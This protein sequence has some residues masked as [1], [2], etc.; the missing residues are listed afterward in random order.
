MAGA[1]IVTVPVLTG[2]GVGLEPLEQPIRA[3]LENVAMDATILKGIQ[4]CCEHNRVM[5]CL[6]NLVLRA[7]DRQKL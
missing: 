4:V 5:D 3:K 1:V 2:G 6:A 7:L